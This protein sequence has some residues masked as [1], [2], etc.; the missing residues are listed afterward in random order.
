[1]R[2]TDDHFLFH[3]KEVFYFCF[4]FNVNEKKNPKLYKVE[5]WIKIVK[6]FLI[7]QK[8]SSEIMKI[9]NISIGNPSCL[10]LSP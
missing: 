3:T 2:Q 10:I 5:N 9:Q 8:Y 4:A 1:M 6:V 7:T